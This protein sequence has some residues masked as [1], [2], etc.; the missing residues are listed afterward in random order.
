MNG[1]R[2]LT[3]LPPRKQVVGCK[4]VYKLNFQVDGTLERHKAR[5]V[6]KGY[7]QQEGVDYVVHFPQ[8]LNW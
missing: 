3:T 5:L 8:W 1:T 7:T 2:S 6:A 4:W